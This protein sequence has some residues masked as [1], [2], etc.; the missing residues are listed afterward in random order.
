MHSDNL[1]KLLRDCGLD[2]DVHGFRSSFRTWAAENKIDD[3]AAE[4]VLAHKEPNPYIRTTLYEARIAIMNDWAKYLDIWPF[5]SRK[6]E[7]AP[8]Q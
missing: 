8:P 3:T 5:P 4:A 2:T 6:G 7:N 1:K